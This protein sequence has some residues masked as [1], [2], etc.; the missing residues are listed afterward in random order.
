[1]RILFSFSVLLLGSFAVCADPTRPARGVSSAA[2]QQATTSLQLHL[3]RWQESDSLVVIDGQ[4]LKTGDVIH[5]YVL[6]AIH[7][8]HVVLARADEQLQLFLFQKMTH[9]DE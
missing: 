1:M 4:L 6:Q 3:I 5:G 7:S 8:D 2:Q 9:N